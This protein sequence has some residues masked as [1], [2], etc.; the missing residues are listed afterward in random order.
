[1]VE[2]RVWAENSKKILSSAAGFSFKAGYWEEPIGSGC[3]CLKSGM[4]RKLEDN[5]EF[6]WGILTNTEYWEEPIGSG[7]CCLKSGMSRK[8]EE[9]IEFG[10]GIL[11]QSEV[12]GGANREWMLVVE[13]R[14][15]TE[16]SNRILG[17]V[18]GFSLKRSIGRSQ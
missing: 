17:L 11:I 14:V 8:L 13:I 18:E 12:L 6:G 9:N 16:D 5:I 10:W 2:I 7:C 3:C 4:C 15:W 1:M